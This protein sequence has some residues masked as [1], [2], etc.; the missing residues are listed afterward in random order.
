MTDLKGRDLKGIADFSKEE[1][2]FTL[3]VAK[4]LKR[5]LKMGK[6]HRLLEGKSLG[7][8]F[9]TP[10]TRTSVSFETAMM[11]LGGHMLWLDQHRLWVGEAAEE[12][13]HDT[14]KTL[15]RYLDGIA[16]RAVRRDRVESAAEYA[17]I[18]LIN[19]SCPVEHPCQ[20][21]AD[22]M[23]MMEKKGPVRNAKV[24]LLWGYRSANPPAGLTNSTM[25]MAGKLGFDLAIAFPEGFEP[26]MEIKK[27]AD[28]EAKLSG[29]SINL[30]HSYEEAAREADFISIYSW[31]SPAVFAKG[32]ETHFQG[33]P[34]FQKKK[35]TLKDEWR[36]DAKTVGM[37]KKDAMVMHCLPV[38]RNDEVTDEVLNSP[39]SIIFD[40]AENRLHTEKAILALLM[41]GYR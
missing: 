32:L 30:V 33:D 29:G 41:G 31:V 19:A 3:E 34:E 36:V 10:S 39:Q 37:A 28:T 17:D 11:Q 5:E 38:A 40:E 2:E 8:I 21:F 20:A 14:I 26:D 18:P 16:Y 24:A 22:V 13:W 25:L 4:Q 35:D 27:A 15:S 23:T 12:D 1:I 9:E 7:G 6:P